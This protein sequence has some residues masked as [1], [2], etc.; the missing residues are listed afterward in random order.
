[1]SINCDYREIKG[2]DGSTGAVEE[3]TRQIRFVGE[4]IQT[5]MQSQKELQKTIS[6]LISNSVPMK[7]PGSIYV[8]PESMMSFKGNVDEDVVI[9]KT[10]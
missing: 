2:L 10:R 8:V 1:M 7:Y 6:D 5:L 9:Q 4:D 3:V